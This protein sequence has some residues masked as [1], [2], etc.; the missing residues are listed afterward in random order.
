M[1]HGHRNRCNQSLRHY[2]FG[3]GYGFFDLE[4]GILST[5]D[6]ANSCIAVIQMLHAQLSFKYS[7]IA[8]IHDY[9]VIN[10]VLQPEISDT[11]C[12]LIVTPT[13]IVEMNLFEEN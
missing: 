8:V 2:A 10:A 7:C 1:S 12:D 9:Q 5:L 6:M 13:Q 3:K 4:W 11:V